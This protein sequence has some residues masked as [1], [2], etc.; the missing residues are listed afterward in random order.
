M[1]LGQGVQGLRPITVRGLYQGLQYADLEDTSGPSG[2]LS[3]LGQPVEQTGRWV[4]RVSVGSKQ[5]LREQHP[6]KGEVVELVQVARVVGG[7]HPSLPAQSAA[8]GSR[9]CAIQIRALMVGM[10]RT[11]GP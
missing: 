10:G 6:G 4:D 11:S 7:R 9:R 1:C 2:R 5:M 3:R 8:S